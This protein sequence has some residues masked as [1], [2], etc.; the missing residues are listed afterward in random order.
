M[1][2][3]EFC[4]AIRIELG[5]TSVPASLLAESSNILYCFYTL[6]QQALDNYAERVTGRWACLSIHGHLVATSS[7]F[8]E[9]DTREARLMLL[10]A[11]AQDGAPLRDT[12]V[13]L[14]QMSPNVSI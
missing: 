5:D 10:L 9:L 3:T 12:P 8:Y 1:A 6:L 11:A 14:P 2:W 7:D 13:Y 4:M